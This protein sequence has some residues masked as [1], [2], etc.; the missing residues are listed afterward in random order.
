MVCRLLKALYGLKQSLQL[1]YKRL[2]TFFLK[3][4]GLKRINFDQS[5]FVTVVGLDGPVV[6]TIVDDIKVM[7]PKGSGMIERVK[8][9]LTSSFSMADMGPISFYLGLKMERNREKK[10]I[11]PFHPE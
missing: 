8:V 9:E 6:S 2:S 7:A 5:V 1:W 10:T 3:K 11:K 4:L